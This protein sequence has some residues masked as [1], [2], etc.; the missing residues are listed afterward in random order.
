MGDTI[1]E[2]HVSTKMESCIQLENDK[3][4]DN[5]G[6]LSLF[7]FPLPTPAPSMQVKVN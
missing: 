4:E 7:V 5:A 1:A 2:T 6:M 3:L